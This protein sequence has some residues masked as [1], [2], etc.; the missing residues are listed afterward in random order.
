MYKFT[1]S[2]LC[3]GWGCLYHLYR[4]E[5]SFAVSATIY[6]GH[7]ITAS[8]AVAAAGGNEITVTQKSNTHVTFSKLIAPPYSPKLNSITFLI[9]T[10]LP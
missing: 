2:E 6:L 3:W 10:E 7:S 1:W 4:L 5:N 8:V 9:D